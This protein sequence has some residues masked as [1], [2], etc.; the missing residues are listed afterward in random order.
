M[1]TRIETESE[2]VAAYVTGNRLRRIADHTSEQSYL[3]ALRFSSANRLA[4][5]Q[6][7]TR[8]RYGRQAGSTNQSPSA[9][10]R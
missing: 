9:P 5:S 2:D 3:R 6:I 8:S 1:A 7:R 4:T 10:T